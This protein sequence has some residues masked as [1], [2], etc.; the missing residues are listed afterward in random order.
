MES[1]D[2]LDNQ[3]YPEKKDQFWRA[4]QPHLISSYSAEQ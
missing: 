3:I 2:I 4:N 1:H